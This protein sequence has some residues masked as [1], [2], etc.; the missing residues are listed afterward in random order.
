MWGLLGIWCSFVFFSIRVVVFDMFFFLFQSATVG[1]RIMV[2]VD[3]ISLRVVPWKV[4]GCRVGREYLTLS[5][6]WGPVF[7]TFVRCSLV[8]FCRCCCFVLF[9]TGGQIL[10]KYP[11][12]LD[13]SNSQNIYNSGGR[14][15]PTTSWEAV[16][17]PIAEWFGV[18]PEEIPNV[19]PNLD[20]F[21]T[22]H[23]ITQNDMFE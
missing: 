12:R 22:E 9:F 10:G 4:G 19:L 2:G 6:L 5:L 16:W 23:I 8:C 21:P 11:S 20:H 17:K 14:F 1:A 18:L 3:I 15:I 13:E 7:W